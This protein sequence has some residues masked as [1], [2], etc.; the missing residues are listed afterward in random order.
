MITSLVWVVNQLIRILHNKSTPTDNGAFEQRKKPLVRV[1]LYIVIL[2]FAVTRMSLEDPDE[3]YKIIVTRAK[4]SSLNFVDKIPNLTN[5]FI[6]VLEFVR[7]WG[8]E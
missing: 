2:R 3:G 5:Q 8:G 6:E 4:S 7:G 1:L